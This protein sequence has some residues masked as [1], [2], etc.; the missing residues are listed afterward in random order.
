MAEYCAEIGRCFRKGIDTDDIEGVVDDKEDELSSD[1][2]YLRK[3]KV[4]VPEK[5]TDQHREFL[6]DVLNF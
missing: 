2:V 6:K 5:L 4:K 1:D 3:Q